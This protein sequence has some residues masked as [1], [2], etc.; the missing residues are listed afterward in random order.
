[1]AKIGVNDGV[2]E[3]R[4]QRRHL[5]ALRPFSDPHR[6]RLQVTSGWLLRDLRRN[7]GEVAEENYQKIDAVARGASGRAGRRATGGWL[8]AGRTRRRRALAKDRAGFRP[9]EDVELVAYPSRRSFFETVSDQFG[10]GASMWSLLGSR[11]EQRAM[12]ALTAPARLFRR[13]E[14]LALMPFAFVR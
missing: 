6:E 2:G 10:G 5:F 14:P 13:G 4:R 11:A 1:M 3:G 12:G 9:N 7:G 8:M